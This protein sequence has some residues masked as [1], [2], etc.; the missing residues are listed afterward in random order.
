[1][2]TK[3]SNL[4]ALTAYARYELG[5]NPPEGAKAADV[6]ALIEAEI[7]HELEGAPAVGLAKDGNRKPF[8]EMTIEEKCNTKVRLIVNETEGGSQQFELSGE[9]PTIQIIKGH[10]VVVPY[11]AW[12]ILDTARVTLYSQKGADDV[13]SKSI[14]AHPFQVLEWDVQE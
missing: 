6:I 1:M 7:G 13:S 4:K 2:V 3:K 14:H 8:S 12:S 10:E 11:A 9:F 5:L